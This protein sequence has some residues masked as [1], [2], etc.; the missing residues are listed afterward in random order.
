MD[1][2]P[3]SVGLGSRC[4]DA[5]WREELAA[6]FN[7]RG[8]GAPR[9]RLLCAAHPAEAVPV[10]RGLLHHRRAGHA[11]EFG[12]L[13]LR[14]G[15]LGL[16]PIDGPGLPRPPR[17]RIFR[18]LR[19]RHCVDEGR[20]RRLGRRDEG[21]PLDVRALGARAHLA[22]VDLL[23][24]GAAGRHVGC[25]RRRHDHR[26]AARRGAIEGRFVLCRPRRIDLR[27]EELPACGCDGS[28]EGLQLLHG[29]LASFLRCLPLLAPRSLR[30]AAARDAFSTISLGS[31]PQPR[32]RCVGF[33]AARAEQQCGEQ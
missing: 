32:G 29:R 9:Y 27:G 13:C 21:R 26:S 10:L 4:G 12:L 24:I 11:G 6:A 19:P 20:A 2:L 25:V 17:I 28:E 5:A 18:C 30:G 15:G 1:D 3:H 14:D 7:A 23:A 8:L 33:V 31:R 16:G 22:L